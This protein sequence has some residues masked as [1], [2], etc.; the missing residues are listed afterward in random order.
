M[1]VLLWFHMSRALGDRRRAE[2]L[3]EVETLGSMHND[4]FELNKWSQFQFPPTM[5]EWRSS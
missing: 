1:E 4:L 5:L 3:L 2:M